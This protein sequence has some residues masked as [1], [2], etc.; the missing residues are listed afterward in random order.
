MGGFAPA[1]SRDFATARGRF[2]MVN[3][4]VYDGGVSYFLRT[5]EGGRVD[6]GKSVGVMF[7][8]DAFPL[9]FV[10]WLVSYAPLYLVL[11]LMITLGKMRRTTESVPWF[12]RVSSVACSLVQVACSRR[13]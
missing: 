4:E 1:G 5:G 9:L 11:L 2:D 13:R 7:A 12:R 6:R 8:L 3:E 10:W